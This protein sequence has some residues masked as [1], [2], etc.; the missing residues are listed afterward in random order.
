[1]ANNKLYTEVI[2]LADSLVSQGVTPDRIIFTP[3][4]VQMV[5]LIR[6]IGQENKQDFFQFYE[7]Y[8]N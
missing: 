1:M 4:G 6:K 8:C 3:E 5:D 7:Q 2:S